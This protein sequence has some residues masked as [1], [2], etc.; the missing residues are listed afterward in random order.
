MARESAEQAAVRRAPDGVSMQDMTGS[1]RI[2]IAR[3]GDRVAT[4]YHHASDD[5]RIIAA[6][7]REAERRMAMW[8]ARP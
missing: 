7:I 2:V 1:W 5:P 4:W 3:K 6:Q 8:V